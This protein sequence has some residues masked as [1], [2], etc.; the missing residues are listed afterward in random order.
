MWIVM[1]SVDKGLPGIIEFFADNEEYSAKELYTHIRVDF[2]GK[3]FEDEPVVGDH[4]S[5]GTNVCKVSLL[6][7]VDIDDELCAMI[8]NRQDEYDRLPM[9]WRAFSDN[10]GVTDNSGVDNTLAERM[11]FSKL[12]GNPHALYMSYRFNEAIPRKEL[13]TIGFDQKLVEHSYLRKRTEG[14]YGKGSKTQIP[15]IA[16]NEEETSYLLIERDKLSSAGVSTVN[17]KT[18]EKP[19]AIVSE[20]TKKSWENKKNE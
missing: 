18:V 8:K 15:E 17:G 11:N 9:E 10:S 13:S 19:Y 3:E 1:A 16:T 20:I 2:L 6:H 14:G 7:T 12:S 5:E 4:A